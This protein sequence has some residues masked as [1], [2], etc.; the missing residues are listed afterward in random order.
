MTTSDDAHSLSLAD[1]DH[2]LAPEYEVLLPGE[3]RNDIL[4]ALGALRNKAA[5]QTHYFY[6]AQEYVTFA[7]SVAPRRW[8]AEEGGTMPIPGLR[9]LVLPGRLR[10]G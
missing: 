3:L 7:T 5:A 1:L 4:H 9:V 2:I 6:S 8:L 10:V